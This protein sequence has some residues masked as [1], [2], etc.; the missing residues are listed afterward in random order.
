[1]SLFEFEGVRPTVHP[2]AWVAPTATL[3]GDVRL[4]PRVSVWYGAVLR[5][6]VGPIVIEEGSNVQDNSVL[7]VRT[8][9]HLHIGAHSTVAH[10]CVVHGREI[11]TRS[12]VGNGSVLLDESVIGSGVLVAAG[13]L[14]TPGTVVPDGMLVKGS[15]AKVTGAVEPGSTPALILEHNA[16]VYIDL[17]ERHRRS[18]R[19]VD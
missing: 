15:P 14:V 13:A 4:G 11:G 18:T 2:E 16:T 7:H 10:G 12:L 1:M 17:M 9:S 19:P 8:G 5:A 3:V 6:D